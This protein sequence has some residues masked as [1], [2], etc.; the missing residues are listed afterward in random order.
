[1]M[2]RKSHKELG[3]C[4]LQYKEKIDD[5]SLRQTFDSALSPERGDRRISKELMLYLI[6]HSSPLFSQYIKNYTPVA[7]SVARICQQ[8]IDS[9]KCTLITKDA[10][11]FLLA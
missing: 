8:A 7:N 9:L 10:L 4:T 6:D 2:S 5:L 3:G 11:N 1:M